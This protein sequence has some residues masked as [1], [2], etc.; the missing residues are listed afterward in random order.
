[1]REVGI[2]LKAGVDGKGEIDALATSLGDAAGQSKLLDTEA[3]RLQAEL[4]KLAQ[5]QALIDSFKRQKQVLADAEAAMLAAKTQASA[6]GRE[7][8]ATEAPTKKQEAAF[9]KARTAAREAGDAYGAQRLKLQELRGSMGAAGVST[10]ALATAQRRVSAEL[11]Q[12][13]AN[14][15]GVAEWAQRAA[16]AEQDAAQGAKALAGS[17]AAAGGGLRQTAAAAQEA[18]GQLKGVGDTL[19]NVAS[20]GVAGILGSETVQMLR[21]VAATADAYANLGARVKLVTGDGQAFTA[22]M[23]GIGE[24]ALR[25]NSNLEATGTLFTRI[26]QAGKELGLSQAASLALTETINQAVQLSGASAEASNAAITQLV[27]G[28]QGGVLRG[29]EFNSVME[30]SPRLAQALAAGL[31]VTTGELRKMAEAGKLSSETV[32]TALQSQSAT[33]QKEFGS[34]PATVGRALEN[35]NTKWTLFVG[36]LNAGTGATASVAAGING[37][38]DNLGNLAEIATRAGTVLVAALAVQAVNALRGMALQMAAT[39]ASAA[40]LTKNISE[41]P[42]LVNI[43]VAIAGLEAAYQVGK[44]LEENFAVARKLGVATVAFGESLFATLQLLKDGVSALFTDSTVA[45]ALD[46]YRTRIAAMREIFQGMYADANELPEVVR[47]RTAEAKR[48]AEELGAAGQAAGAQVAA[49]GAAGAAGLAATTQAGETATAALQALG[50]AAESARKGLAPASAEATRQADALVKLA[51]AGGQAARAVGTELS[52]A[53]AKLSGPELEQFR[54]AMTASLQSARTEAQRLGEQ[55]TAAGNDGSAAFAKAEQAG[56]LLAQVAVEVGRRAA[57]ALGVDVAQAAGVVSKEFAAAET[58]LSLLTRSMPALAAAGIDAGKA[59]AD[60][61]A[62]MI[63]GAKTQAEIDAV[64]ARLQALG[65]AGQLS[66]AQVAAGMEQAAARAKDLRK[67]IEDATPGIQSLEEAAR[68]MGIK[69][70]A[71]LEQTAASFRD[72]WD[73]ISASTEVTMAEKIAAFG[74]YREAAIAA[75]GGVE[76]STLKLETASLRLKAEVAGLGNEFEKAMGR[77]GAALDKTTQQVDVLGHAI[78]AAGERVNQVAMGFA[79]VTEEAKRAED[80]ALR[81]GTALNSTQYDGDKFAL[82]GNGGRFTASGQLQPP[83]NSGDW[84]FVGDVRVRSSSSTGARVNVP[85]Q[86]YWKKKG[87]GAPQLLGGGGA[88]PTGAVDD[89]GAALFGSSG[90]N[91][92]SGSSGSSGNGG[93][94]SNGSSASAPQAAASTRT[95]RLELGGGRNLSYAAGSDAEVA[96]VEQLLRTLAVESQRAAA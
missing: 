66:G 56:R 29:D 22:A 57:E 88:G 3:G 84:E 24:I 75:N 49:G 10:E 95:L 31:G 4:Q 40:L 48:A 17:A 74:R 5:Q 30:Q 78:N 63:G 1:M 61:L 67:A 62:K 16:T 37:L 79:R 86:G 18:T 34:L 36:N 50:A 83:D 53:I 72:S 25:T 94:S 87:S 70:R 51:L 11:A 92:S 58:N 32:I 15:R 68:T 8:S 55:L 89:R 42:K 41:I 73:R 21:S 35:L 2:R 47:A 85:G 7:I 9:S 60:A 6:L 82:N 69:T 81:Y 90:S 12:A 76:S 14:L 28:L 54:V 71:E 13:Q 43:T 65:R 64:V 44:V 33:L 26:A 77:S 39:G 91:G 52:G 27:Q 23:A 19:R 45:A 59:V 80:A 20:I 93:G 46:T 96:R 38:A